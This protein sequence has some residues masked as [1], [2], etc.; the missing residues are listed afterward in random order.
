MDQDDTW[1]GGGPWSR[2][3]CARW[4]PV[5]L[6]KRGTAPPIFGQRLLW[7]NGCMDQDATW[8][9]GRP[10]PTRQCVRWWPSSPPLK[11]HSTQFSANVRCGQMTGWTKMPLGM[12]VDLGPGDFVFDGNP[13][14][15]C[16]DVCIAATI[17]YCVAADSEVH[18]SLNAVLQT[19]NWTQSLDQLSAC[20]E[21]Q[22]TTG[23][24]WAVLTVNCLRLGRF[25]F[26]MFSVSV[27]F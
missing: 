21:R 18:G 25:A 1:H 20:Y 9:E 13:S 17:W 5:P 12:E 2:P 22:S 26:C 14:G 23:L 11:G 15:L 6:L 8:Y 16:V 19:N 7:P 10:R 27:C 4:G 24:L 3:H